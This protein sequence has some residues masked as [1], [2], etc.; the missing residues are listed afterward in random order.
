MVYSSHTSGEGINMVEWIIDDDKLFSD[1]SLN[2]DSSFN[3]FIKNISDYAY[4]KIELEQ[5]F[6]IE[7]KL[8]SLLECELFL[9]ITKKR[10]RDHLLHACRIAHLGEIILTEKLIY[11]GK[12]LSLLDLVRE[13]YNE[14]PEIVE[15]FALFELEISNKNILKIW[16]IGAL[17]HDI[18]FIYEAFKEKDRDGSLSTQ[19]AY[20]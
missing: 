3:E 17:F 8:K 4:Q 15:R 19:A 6:K 12:S 10:H 5:I 14:S 9:S 13:L 18:G 2:K 11:K 20:Q 1:F 16:Y 7:D